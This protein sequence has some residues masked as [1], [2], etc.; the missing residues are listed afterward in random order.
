MK[1]LFFIIA[2][3][4]FNF[5][6]LADGNYHYYIDLTKTNNDKL[7]ITL[8]PPD[9]TE[10]ETVFMFPAMVPGTYEVYDFGR[11]V[12]NFKATGK[13]GEI[14]KIEKLDK[15]S[16]KLTPANAIKEITY[17]VDDT[18]DSDIKEKFVF[19]PGGTNIEEG[20]NYSLNTHGFFGYLKNKIEAN[21]ILE[22]IKPEGFYP[23]T[24]ISNIKCGT[25]KDVISIFNY[26]NLVDAPI[27][28]CKPDTTSIK[29][30]NSTILF[31]VYSPNNVITSKFVA[32]NLTELLLS[33]ANYLG[34]T[35]PIEK[36][37]FLFYFTD[38]PSLS[39]SNG[40][41]EHSYSSFYFL[42]EA[43]TADLAQEIR[44]VAAHE[45]FHIVTPLNIHSKEIGEFDFNNPKMSKHLW[46]YEGL[47]EYAAHHM[48]VK[49]GLIEYD[50]F[51]EEMVEKMRN[52]R[53]YNDTVPFTFM[54][55]NALTPQYKAQYGNVYE[56]GA[57]IGMCLDIE[58]RYYSNGKY[59]TQDLMFDL[60]QQYGKTKSFNDDDLFKDIEKLTYIEIAYFL[61]NYVS[62]MQPLPFMEV[63]NMVGMKY[64]DK[65]VEQKITLGG[66]AVGYNP[67]SSH[68]IVVNTTK[69][70]EFGKKLKFK[71][72]D[73]I[74]T[75][76]NRKLTLDNLKEVLG[77]YMENA[78]TGDK[79]VIEILRKDK[80][81]NEKTK[82]LK[83]KVKPVEVTETDILE[84]NDKATEQQLKARKEWL[85]IN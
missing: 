64:I 81:G 72:G 37:A 78:K 50:A 25:T 68:L 63:F 48:Q 76:N 15:N 8:T 61:K 53:N 1:Q 67:K 77:G 52:A 2:A 14:I 10:N 74:L 18:W 20:K 54:S 84:I 9:I 23:S 79:L 6:L 30:G 32:R 56:K 70:D 5:S 66:I 46:L 35:L 55:K 80:K 27:M 7:S 19:E 51:F 34:G 40:A 29:I 69:L 57:L 22:F 62:G 73:E 47:T 42:P 60:A 24:S 83:A 49:T 28:Y 36:Y 33:Q 4:A 85:G 71:E 65:R 45:F 39:G 41:L 31:S 58:L 59:G 82:T 26:H 3:L 75:F 44:D 12:S 17:D 16:Y 43:D 21:F 13:N 11:F 38:K